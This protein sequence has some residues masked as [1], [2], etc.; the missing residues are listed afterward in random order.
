[1]TGSPHEDAFDHHRGRAPLLRPTRP[2]RWAV[3]LAINLIGFAVVNAF[4]L[5]L[6]TG[7]WVNFSP[8]AYQRD[9]A[10]PVG[11]MLLQ[12]LSVFRYPWMV[13]ASGLL[14]AV[15]IFVPVV[16]SVLYRLPFAAAFVVMIAAVGHA[17]LLA[18]T[19]AL[20]CVLAGRTTWRSRAP[21]PGTRI[22]AAAPSEISTTTSNCSPRACSTFG[23][24]RSPI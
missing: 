1:M 22:L 9:L 2:V 23:R 17:P 19:V 3:F 13:L 24:S 12:P 18:L 8:W 7:E 16:V 14:L 4:W 20:G 21:W 10:S 5:Y 6:S 11:G 15:V